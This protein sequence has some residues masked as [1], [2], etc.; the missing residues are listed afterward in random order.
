MEGEEEGGGE[1]G[2]GGGGGGLEDGIIFEV[3]TS[4]EEGEVTPLNTTK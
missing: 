2:R 1:R 3:E 4:V